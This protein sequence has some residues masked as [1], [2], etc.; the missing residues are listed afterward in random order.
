M[1]PSV[2][3]SGTADHRVS[4][5][6]PNRYEEKKAIV[7]TIVGNLYSSLYDSRIKTSD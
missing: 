7:R 5:I 4:L 6:C 1:Q 3:Q 2:D